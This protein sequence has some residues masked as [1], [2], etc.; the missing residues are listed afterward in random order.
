MLNSLIWET[1]VFC[2]RK[3]QRVESLVLQWV[4]RGLLRGSCKQCWGILCY[5]FLYF[6]FNYFSNPMF[7]LLLMHRQ[8]EFVITL[9]CQFQFSVVPSIVCRAQNMIATIFSN[10]P[11]GRPVEST[12]D[13][14]PR[15]SFPSVARKQKT[16]AQQQLTPRPRKPAG[17]NSGEEAKLLYG[18]DI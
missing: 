2:G 1:F 12:W 11:C 17:Y 9:N 15:I 6:V 16:R 3:M 7:A 14:S 4:N 5:L 10:N 8:A 13:P 18:M